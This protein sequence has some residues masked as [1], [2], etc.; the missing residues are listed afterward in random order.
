MD[1]CQMLQKNDAFFTQEKD[2]GALKHD[3]FESYLRGAFPVLLQNPGKDVVYADLYAGAG[4]YDDGT[5]G[6]PL[7]AARLAARRYGAGQPP[8][9]SC[10]NVELVP[11]TYESLVASMKEIPE[12]VVTN[13]CG[14]WRD[15][16]G[17]LMAAIRD[18]SAVLFMDPFGLDVE[19]EDI[20]EFIR[21]IGPE[22]RDLILRLPIRDVQRQIEAKASEDAKRAEAAVTGADIGMPWRSYYP[23]LNALFGGTWWKEHLVEGHLPDSSFDLLVR[24]YCEQLAVLEPRHRAPRK[25]VAVPIPK[26]LG[27]PTYY[28]LILVSRSAKAITLFSDATEGAFER[29]WRKKEGPPIVAP[30]PGQLSLFGD[31]GPVTKHYPDRR[32]HFLDAL[33]PEVAAYVERRPWPTT[34]RELHEVL[35]MDHVGRFREEHLRGIVSDLRERGDVFTDVSAIKPSTLIAR[36]DLWASTRSA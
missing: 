4:L 30:L 9:I 21:E 22:A 20:S 28:Y 32:R 29:A 14:E 35:A 5:V 24:G 10:F 26:L 15:Y 19:L 31:T 27:G 8:F 13:R 36:E 34:F 23:R 16:Q 3:I 12:A 7:F 2:A 18:R 25:T 17:E 33:A 1:A 6:S 11:R